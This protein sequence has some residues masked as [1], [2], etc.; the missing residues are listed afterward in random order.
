MERSIKRDHAPFLQGTIGKNRTVNGLQN[1][2]VLAVLY[3]TLL[4]G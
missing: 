2:N 3:Y 1:I 4:S